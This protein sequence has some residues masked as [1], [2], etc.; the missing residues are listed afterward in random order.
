MSPEQL[1]Q[2]HTTRPVCGAWPLQAGEHWRAEF[3]APLGSLS[4]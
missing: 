3:S 2:H 4:A 1:L